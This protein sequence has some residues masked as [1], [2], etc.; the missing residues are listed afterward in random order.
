MLIETGVGIIFR[1]ENE[2]RVLVVRLH[3]SIARSPLSA[4][5]ICGYDHLFSVLIAS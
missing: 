1:L 3:E 4:P 2:K 5:P